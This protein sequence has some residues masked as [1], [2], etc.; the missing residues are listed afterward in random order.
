MSSNLAYKEERQEEL[1][2]GK[3]VMMSPRPA[4]NHNQVSS[5]IYRLFANYLYGKKCTPIADG[6]DL[7]LDENNRF[8][9]DFMVVCDPKKI[10]WD[11]V[12][13]APD[14]VAEVLSPSTTVNDRQLKREA[15]EKHG[16]REYWIVNPSDKVI[17]QYLLKNGRLILSMAYILYPDYM[18]KAMTKEDLDKV[19]TSFKCSLFDD[20]EISLADVFRGLLPQEGKA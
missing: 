10:Q 12:H 16:V 6:T 5:N 11:G 14:L 9:P 17:E 18:L 1:I 7:Y 20:L 3:V 2:G 19:V 13:G 8:V 4:F 15:Y